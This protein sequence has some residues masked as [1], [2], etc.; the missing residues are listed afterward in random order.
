MGPVSFAQDAKSSPE[1]QGGQQGTLEAASQ[2]QG[3]A[4]QAVISRWDEGADWDIDPNNAMDKMKEEVDKTKRKVKRKNQETDRKRRELQQ[5]IM[6]KI[7]QFRA[8]MCAEMY[9]EH[10][11]DFRQAEQCFLFMK[12]ACMPGS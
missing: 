10:G 7:N 2:A 11:H 4:S 9:I 1:L 8:Q 12:K 6:N 5:K 3:R